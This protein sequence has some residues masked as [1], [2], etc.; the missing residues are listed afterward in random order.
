[1]IVSKKDDIRRIKKK[2]SD[3]LLRI[4]GKF[5]FNILFFLVQKMLMMIFYANLDKII[6]LMK[7]RSFNSFA[8]VHYE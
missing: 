6:Y 5:S 8:Q 1:M 4:I 2:I 3:L 7:W